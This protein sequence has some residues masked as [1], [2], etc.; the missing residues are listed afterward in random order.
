MVPLSAVVVA[1]VDVPAAGVPAAEPLPPHVSR[2]L[3]MGVPGAEVPAP[4][5]ACRESQG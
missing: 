4:E 5:E 1:E 2:A 3:A